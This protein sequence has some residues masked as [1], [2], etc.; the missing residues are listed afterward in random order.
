AARALLERPPDRVDRDRGGDRARAPLRRDRAPHRRLGLR[1]RD[2]QGRLRPGLDRRR[3]LLPRDDAVVSGVPLADRGPTPALSA[4]PVE[5][6]A[7]AG[8]GRRALASPAVGRGRRRDRALRSAPDRRVRGGEPVRRPRSDHAQCDDHARACQRRHRADGDE[9]ER[10]GRP[11]VER[12]ATTRR[13]GVL[14]RVARPRG[15]AHLSHPGGRRADLQPH[16]AGSGDDTRRDVHRHAEAGSLGLP[17]R[18]RRELAERRRLRRPVHGQPARERHDPVSSASL[19]AAVR[20]VATTRVAAACGAALVAV[21][22]LAV[23]A[24]HHASPSEVSPVV[25]SGGWNGAWIAA[26]VAAVCLYGLGT[27][28]AWNG[29]LKLRVALVVAVA[30]QAIP[31]AAPLLLSKDAYLYWGEGRVL[32]VH[33]ANPYVSTPADFPRD[34][35]TPWVSESWRAEP[36]PYGPAWEVVGAAPAAAGS[37][38]A[39]ELGYRF[40]AV[41]TLL[42][43]LALVARRTRNAAA[44]AFLGW[45]P[46]VALHYGGGGHSDSTMMLF[47]LAAV[48]AGATFRGGAFWPLASAFKPFPPVL[49]PLELARRRLDVGRRWWAGLVGGAVAVIVVS[50]A[51]FGTH[52]ISAA[53]TGAHQTSPLG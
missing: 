19:T 45:S 10:Q 37:H 28:A 18:R 12:A 52:W 21:I 6:P 22:A 47:V 44:V 41:A 32:A 16:A 26:L 4:R 23:V 25:P 50:T 46:L 17:R 29:A 15:H 1:L 3:E 53:T 42:G 33:H 49:V 9:A 38:R 20:P 2:R 39:A 8:R 48:T 34:P 5:A 13:A 40:L 7:V 31:L 30:V 24:A 36:A 35:A 51:L 27:L 43:A 14:P 11:H